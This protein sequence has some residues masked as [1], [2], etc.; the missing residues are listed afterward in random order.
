MSV[1]AGRAAA[2]TCAACVEPASHLPLAPFWLT[3]STL[4]GLVMEK[5]VSESAVAVTVNGR[6]LH[7]FIQ[8]TW[9]HRFPT[10]T[11]TRRNLKATP[12][13]RCI[14]NKW[15]WRQT[16]R[17]WGGYLLKGDLWGI[18][19]T[20]SHGQ[21]WLQRLFRHRILTECWLCLNLCAVKVMK[22]RMNFVDI[23]ARTTKQNITRMWWSVL[24]V[25]LRLWEGR[26]GA[27]GTGFLRRHC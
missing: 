4:S 6:E 26:Y 14:A 27:W 13:P 22:T 5:C 1:T 25:F 7:L 17:I 23:K 11:D 2:Q 10:P 20:A 8:L 21:Q 24:A 3:D 12:V 15:S 19:N 16:N 18:Q 9:L